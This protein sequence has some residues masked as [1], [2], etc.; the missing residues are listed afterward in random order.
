MI[1]QRRRRWT[2]S[3]R[4]RRWPAGCSSGARPGSAGDP[5]PASRCRSP[6]SS[7][8]LTPFQWAAVDGADRSRR[9][10]RPSSGRPAFS[11]VRVLHANPREA[12]RSLLARGD[13]ASA[14]SRARGRRTTETAEASG[15]GRQSELY[16][17]RAVAEERCPGSLRRRRKKAGSSANGSALGVNAED[18]FRAASQS[19][20]LRHRPHA[21]SGAPTACRKRTTLASAERILSRGSQRAGRRLHGSGRR[22]DPGHRRGALLRRDVDGLI[23]LLAAKPRLRDLAITTNGVLLAEGGRALKAAG[24]HRVTVSLEHAPPDRSPAHAALPTRAVLAASA[25]CRPPAH[26]TKLDTVVMRGVNDDEL[27]DLIE[28]GKT[29]PRGALIEYMDVGGATH[30]RWS[31]L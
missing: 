17:T 10:S 19:P 18:I 1:G 26:R 15:V 7:P 4:F 24:L 21:T 22:Q 23:R 27:A 20:H 28:F 13:A 25:R 6:R 3:A 8:T 12:A 9:S 2:T 5:R 30:G 14:I 16:T 11:N 31:R 29:V